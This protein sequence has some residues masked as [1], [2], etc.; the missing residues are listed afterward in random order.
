VG[1]GWT[2]AQA[3]DRAGVSQPF[4][5]D[6]ER[7]AA[8]GT[9][10]ETLA[11]V[12][13]AAGMVLAAFLE[14]S[15]GADLPRDIEHVRRQE[16]VIRFAA[17]G[18]WRAGPETAIDARA[19]RSRSVDVL[20]ERAAAREIAVVEIEDLVTDVGG[21]FRGLADKVAAVVRERPGW[22]AAG[23]LIVRATHRNRALI[24]ELRA[25]FDARFPGSSSAWVRALADSGT[26]MPLGDGVA[27]SSVRGDRLFARRR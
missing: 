22:R 26:A 24:D 16:L 4:W 6:L 3:A 19:F 7:G 8:T 1:A 5:S 17:R 27:W 13:A 23:L 15:A 10:L 20:L 14:S 11:T 9:S 18:S 25:T 2:Q 12:G 21:A